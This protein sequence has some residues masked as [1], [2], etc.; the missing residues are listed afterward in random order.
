[1]T[2]EI[3]KAI[4][5]TSLA[6]SAL[7]L[8]ITLL[9]PITKKFFGYKWHYYIWLA[10]LVVMMLPVRFTAWQTES[11]PI[12]IVNT[13]D[14]QT[15]PNTEIIT[16][17]ETETQPTAPIQTA[18]QTP[19]KN[20]AKLLT[21]LI[22]NRVNILGGLWI[23]GILIML[24]KNAIGYIRL[25][26]KV[27]KKSVIISCPEIQEYTKRN[28]TVRTCERLSSPFMFGIL[29]PTLVLPNVSLT[30]EQLDNILMHEMT[31]FKR[32]DLLYKWFAT[33]VKAIHWFNPFSYYIAK[34]INTECEISCDLSV[35]KN[36]D[37][38]QEMTYVNTIISL[39][40]VNKAKS[41][42]LTTGMTGNKKM[43]KR[44]FTMIRN[45]K[46]TSKLM[47]LLSALVAVVMLTTTVFASGVLSDIAKDDYR[48]ELTYDGE[49][50]DL[51][52]KP[53]I[54][55]G[56]IYFPLRETLEKIGVMDIPESEIIWNNGRIDV[57]I[58]EKVKNVE[59]EFGVDTILYYYAIEIGKPEIIMNTHPNLAGQDVSSTKSLNNTPI[60]KDS[61]TYIPYN[62][63]SGYCLMGYGKEGATV[64][65]GYVIYDK[66]DNVL[67]Y[68][69]QKQ[70]QDDIYMLNAEELTY[71]DIVNLQ[72]QVDNGHYPW[73]L[74]PKQVINEFANTNE[75]GYGEITD[76][77][78]DEG[79]CRARYKVNE[80][81][82]YEFELIQ[83]MKNENGIWIVSWYSSNKAQEH[84]LETAQQDNIRI[85]TASNPSSVVNKFFS[86]FAQS[87]FE[88]MK[89]Y[90]T[91]E[92]VNVFFNGDNVFGMTKAEVSE[93]RIPVKYENSSTDRIIGVTVNMTPHKNSIYDPNDTQT[94]FNVHLVQ[95]A[96]GRY[97]IDGF[98]R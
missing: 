29:K 5:I 23:L 40:A 61:I 54:Q 30:Q 67:Q 18:P 97:L 87:D 1:M 52:N 3:L 22:E 4:L 13:M 95:Q 43:L 31:H 6:G 83:P 96:D 46:T 94:T 98:G 19:I 32:N 17:D 41:I 57:T 93:M 51:K 60:L 84:F 45:K 34:Q 21:S 72:K 27:H 35:V 58:A 49:V 75:L 7:A 26:H 88:N 25:L 38:T 90:C 20:G 66:N 47:S 62:D 68:V 70:Y 59:N 33:L 53:F 73:R 56:D 44:R 92:C 36:M 8:V 9:K 80:E 14:M 12:P 2:E 71:S 74:N 86:L 78:T 79:K 42:P 16:A 82:Y 85:Y 15:V 63:L 48:I 11:A 89:K 50:L 81:L 77:V 76:I 55:N 28:V 10:V 37:S 39:L 24:L 65:I 64:G 91:D 69:G